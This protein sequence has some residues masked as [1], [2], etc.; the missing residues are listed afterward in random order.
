MC[1]TPKKYHEITSYDR[2]AMEPHAM[3]W[4]G[5][6]DPYKSYP[7][8]KKP[9]GEKPGLDSVALPEID[10][11]PEAALEAVYGP[12]IAEPPEAAPTLEALSKI[13][14]LSGG[15][16]ARSRQGS[17]YFYFRSA[18]SAGALYPN[19]MYYAA[20]DGNACSSG[21]YH[22]GIH[23]RFL[24]RLRDGCFT[25]YLTPAIPELPANAAGVFIISGIFFRSAWK[26]RKRAYRYVL[27]D[28]GHLAEN[29]RLAISAAG[30]VFRLHH[31]FEDRKLDTLLGIDESREGS[32]CCVSISGGTALEAGSGTTISPLPRWIQ[33]A[34]RVSSAEIVY[35]EIT[36]M[37]E[38]SK[39]VRQENAA[40]GAVMDRLGLEVVGGYLKSIDSAIDPPVLDYSK[41]V[42]QRRSKRNFIF[43]A[44]GNNQLNYMLKL[45]CRT[46]G[47]LIDENPA[48]SSS[49][50]T[51]FVV[52]N[53]KGVD[54]GFY[55]LDPSAEKTGQ[56]FSGSVIEKM[57]AVC[58]NQAWLKNAA[59]HFVFMT[60]LAMLEE[61]WGARGYRYAMLTA[62]RLGHAVYLGATALNLG[63]CGIGA[64][65]DNEARQVLGL[66]K[67]S[68]L[69]Y[70][71]A[72]G[73]VRLK[74]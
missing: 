60:H 42:L 43:A 6:P 20:F 61:K 31:A 18:P 11:L 44:I 55:L 4:A 26:Y 12:K 45:L 72:V 57:T 34:S 47:E 38:A 36:Q 67:D 70:L 8:G 25:K 30:Y 62:G 40:S 65:Y 35:P 74:V 16:T 19:E 48:V 66:N 29:L 54:P 21:I 46:T 5:R 32:I 17:E 50:C 7:I 58:L 52:G 56:V 68:A 33:A 73:K 69:L 63:C 71:V 27:L 2:S 59:I 41:T 13:C 23:N 22:C 3:D 10:T 39:I 64:L 15:L 9:V 14:L 51:G 49:V 1:R 24:T 53:V 28:G 37:H